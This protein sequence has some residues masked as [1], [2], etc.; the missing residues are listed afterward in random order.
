MDNINEEILWEQ[1]RS[2]YAK[3]TENDTENNTNVKQVNQNNNSNTKC[4]N[5][6]TET[7]NSNFIIDNE[8]YICEEC[9]YIIE[10][11]EYSNYTFENPIDYKSTKGTFTK[12]F[13]KIQKMQEWL[14]WTNAEKNEYKLKKYTRDFCENL[15]IHENIIENVCLLVIKV[16]NSIREKNDGPKRSRV[17]DGIIISCI[18]YISKENNALNSAGTYNYLEL[19]KKINL[20]IKYVSKADKILMELNLLNKQISCKTENPIDY[21]KYAINKY[22]LSIPDNT[23]IDKV[24]LLINICEDNDILLDHT[25]LSIGVAC[26]YYILNKSNIEIDVKTFAS[27]F[28]LSVVT[29]TKTFN[30][31]KKYEKKIDKMIFKN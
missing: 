15:Q 13:N 28:D 14:S 18:Y 29:V 19:A 3:Y 11:I 4:P 6:E 26:F 16:M 9:G 17:K 22:N 10:S 23:I 7:D 25:P 24:T 2:A 5:C 31:L 27:I 12:K 20:D 21:I 1:A 30:K 8:G